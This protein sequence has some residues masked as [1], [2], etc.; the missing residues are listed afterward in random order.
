VAYNC[1]PKLKITLNKTQYEKK[2]R[3]LWTIYSGE[4]K[5][6]INFLP[7]TA[8]ETFVQVDVEEVEAIYNF[9]NGDG[10][11][12]KRAVKVY[13]WLIPYL[14]AGGATLQSRPF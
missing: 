8:C 12:N 14:E 11:L 7:A 4:T 2:T 6:L 10:P 9:I 5:R 3:L 13:E 1:F